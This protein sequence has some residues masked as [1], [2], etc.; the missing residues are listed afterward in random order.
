ME[1][2]PRLPDEHLVRAK[3]LVLENRTKSNCKTCY[4]RGYRGVNQNN[5]LVY[6]YK[7]VDNDALMQA[8]RA[9]VRETPALKEIYGDYFEE[10]EAEEEEGGEEQ[11]K[12]EQEK[13]EKEGGEE[14]EKEE[15]K[16]G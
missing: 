7:C 4:D 16:N 13:Q 11:E 14:Q 10:D 6:C 12:E 3:E 2:M 9:Y 8:W 5:M 15:K 1:E